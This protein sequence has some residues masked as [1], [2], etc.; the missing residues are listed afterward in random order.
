M[1][2]LNH[3]LDI[4]SFPKVLKRLYE[5]K[6]TVMERMRLACTFLDERE[7][8]VSDWETQ[9]ECGDEGWT[10]ELWQGLL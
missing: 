7:K 1:L 10:Q 8:R 2:I 3:T 5:G 6:A 9:A 4:D